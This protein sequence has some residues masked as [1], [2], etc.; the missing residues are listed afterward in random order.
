M[1]I[2][3]LVRYPDYLADELLSLYESE[4]DPDILAAAQGIF[5]A[6]EPDV[7]VHQ[8]PLSSR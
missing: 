1:A 7:S 4:R 3:F 5:D 8:P 6:S 2:D